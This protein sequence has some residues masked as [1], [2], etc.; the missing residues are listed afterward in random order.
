MTLTKEEAQRNKYIGY[1]AA[2][3]NSAAIYRNQCIGYNAGKLHNPVKPDQPQPTCYHCNAPPNTG[4]IQMMDG[5][6]F[7]GPCWIELMQYLSQACKVAK[8]KAKEWNDG[9]ENPE[10]I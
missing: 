7:C 5:P 8:M 1:Q 9:Q 2:K 6:M 3:N 10:G 4:S